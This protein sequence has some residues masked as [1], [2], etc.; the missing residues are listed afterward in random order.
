MVSATQASL[1]VEAG[2][3]LKTIYVS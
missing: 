1:K 3:W 2:M